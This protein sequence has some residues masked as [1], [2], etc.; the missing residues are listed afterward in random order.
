MGCMWEVMVVEEVFFTASR[1]FHL[2]TAV[3]HRGT[4]CLR[5][6]LE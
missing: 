5:S 6:L 2:V 3:S 4:R 1:L